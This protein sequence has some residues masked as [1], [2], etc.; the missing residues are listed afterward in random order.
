[1]A[2]RTL[3]LRWT[4][5]R[6]MTVGAVGTVLDVGGFALLHTALGLPALPAN[7]LS[8]SLG[9]LNNY[10]LHRR[11]TYA[12]RPAKSAR[13]QFLQFL[14]VS[15]SALAL[16]TAL[17]LLLTAAFAPS[18]P[19]AYAGLLAKLCATGVGLGWN[20]LL[21]NFWTFRLTGERGQP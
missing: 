19:A 1:M 12:G 21:N 2:T 7:V 16:N 8:Y 14:A 5:A 4:V 9:I 6:F 17:V 18:L 13:V 3:S 11:W 15:L 10:L 20:F